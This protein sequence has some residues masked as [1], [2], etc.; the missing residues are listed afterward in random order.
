MAIKRIDPIMRVGNVA[1]SVAYYRD[2]LGF[3][4]EEIGSAG[5]Q[6]LF[7]RLRRDGAFILLVAGD[8][9]KR[10]ALSGLYLEVDDISAMYGEL[11]SLGAAPD[12]IH[13]TRH[14]TAEV[15]VSDPDGH[16]VTFGQP[17][18]SA[19]I[20]VPEIFDLI[21]VG[22][23]DA[24]VL[25]LAADP[26]LANTTGYFWWWGGNHWTAL[27]VAAAHG[28]LD[29]ARLLL[30]HGADVNG[31]D[32]GQPLDWTP[33]QLASFSYPDVAKLLLDRG[34]EVDVFSVAGVGDAA[35]L[36]EGL[37]VQPELATSVG[38]DGATPLHFAAAGGHVECVRILLAHG[39]DPHAPDADRGET[40][41]DWGKAFP[42]VLELLEPIPV[43]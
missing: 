7:A 9:E 39:A 30:D 2:V 1:R 24:L 15:D 43:T 23:L 36:E 19:G 16:S 20:F 31:G 21:D 32:T 41:A 10:P 33:L 4:I 29:A 42:E 17:L 35:A 37:S 28:R 12:P 6:P 40:P 5:E 26:S 3:A 14:G 13:P 22:N 11:L 38:P 8:F 18:Q 34:A 25:R 27:E